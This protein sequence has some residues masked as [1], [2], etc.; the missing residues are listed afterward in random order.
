MLIEDHVKRVEAQK[1]IAQIKPKRMFFFGP[2]T[3]QTTTPIYAS[4]NHNTFNQL[5]KFR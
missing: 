1:R 5:F 3:A 2:E 4:Q